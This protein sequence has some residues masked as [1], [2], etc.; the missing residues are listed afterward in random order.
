MVSNNNAVYKSM[1][2]WGRNSCNEITTSKHKSKS[3]DEVC[4]ILIDREIVSVQSGCKHTLMLTA[5][6]KVYTCGANTYGELG[7]QFCHK[8]KGPLCVTSLL[9]RRIVQISAKGCCHNLAMTDDGSVYSWGS[10]CF[11]QL[12]HGDIIMSTSA[13]TEINSLR[14]KNII[15]VHAGGG[16]DVGY[17]FAVTKNRRLYSWGCNKTGQLALTK[18]GQPQPYPKLVHSI[19]NVHQ[20][21]LGS[22]HVLCLTSRGVLIWGKHHSGPNFAPIL[23]KCFT[24]PEVIKVEAGHN[25][26]FIVTKNEVFSWGNNTNG[27]LGLG[28]TYN[29]DEPTSIKELE[30]R[31]VKSI[32]AGSTNIT[33]L[34]YSGDVLT[35]GYNGFENR[36]GHDEL[37]EAEYIPRE[38]RR[39]KDQNVSE[40]MGGSAHQFA[41]VNKR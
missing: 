10:D 27:Q 29:V 32:V 28:H 22:F 21:S 5:S 7:V 16:A 20:I 2:S 6:G 19:D 18:Q 30:D 23:L 11:G 41:L 4:S 15:S 31:R 12:G 34:L 36:L 17:S 3:I 38:V 14:S 40:I 8:L 35:W 37:T 33:C 26:S 9:G 39:L 13:P 1:Y 24:F 25:C